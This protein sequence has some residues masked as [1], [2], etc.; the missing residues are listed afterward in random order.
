MRARDLSHWTVGSFVLFHLLMPLH[1]AEPKLKVP[2]LPREIGKSVAIEIHGLPAGATRLEVIMVP[3]RG[4]VKPF[5]LG[6]FEVTQ[7]QYEAVMGKN[8]STFK[9]GPDYPV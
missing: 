1:G 8:P 2:A 5:L 4:A 3:G 7:V 9:N 6:K